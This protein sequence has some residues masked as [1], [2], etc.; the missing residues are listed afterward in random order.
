[1]SP[2]ECP[3][4]GRAEIPWGTPDPDTIHARRVAGQAFWLYEESPCDWRFAPAP[5]GADFWR[6]AD[7]QC[8]CSAIAKKREGYAAKVLHWLSDRREDGQR[9]DQEDLRTRLGISEHD[10]SEFKWYGVSSRMEGLEPDPLSDA[11][12]QTLAREMGVTPGWLLS[13]DTTWPPGFK[14]PGVECQ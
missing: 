14:P 3:S 1:M 12:V 5:V 7:L 8:P 13:Q 2:Y 11:Q 6:T 4:C 9:V 10:W